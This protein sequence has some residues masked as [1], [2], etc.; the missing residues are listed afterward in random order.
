MRVLVTNDDGV[1]AP[2]LVLLASTLHDQGHDVFV[3]AP[4]RERSG[5]GTALGTLDDGATFAIQKVTLPGL[6]IEAHGIDAPPAMGVLA[7]GLGQFGPAPDLVVSGINPGHNT[8]RSVL[9]SST[10]G[11]ALAAVTMGVPAIAISCGFAPTHRFD[12]AA[13]VAG[14]AALWM[15]S[16]KL[17]LLCVNINVPDLDLDQIR[18]IQLTALS[19]RSLFSLGFER[20]ENFLTLRRVPNNAKLGSRTDSGV[21]QS[22]SISVSFLES[23]GAATPTVAAEDLIEHL[24]MDLSKVSST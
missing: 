22:G 23:V 9:F 18:D 3:V 20:S 5:S 7:A 16:Q 8:G 15:Q 6:D 10:V 21:V 24:G 17:P 12:T 14:R 1:F 4:L 2:G 19:G 13:A 11:G